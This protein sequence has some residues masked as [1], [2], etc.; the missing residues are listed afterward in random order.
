MSEE[1]LISAVTAAVQAEARAAAHR[2][3]LVAEVTARQC[4]DEDDES[5][6]QLIDGWALAKAQL[7]AACNLGPMAAAK[8]MRIAMALR[9]RLPR[10]AAV[11]ATGSVST[12]VI[13][14]ITWRTRLVTDPDAG[15]LIDAAI[16]AEAADYGTRS[17]KGL[18]DAVDLWVEKFDPDAVVRSDA[19][20]KDIYVEF[21][22]KDDPNGVA[23]FWGRLRVTD[24]KIVQQRLDDLAAT[25]C[26]DDPRPVRQRRADALATLAT[27]GPQATRLTCQ[28]AN[29]ECAGSGKD[30]RATAVVIYALTDRKPPAAT[31]TPPP[32]ARTVPPPNTP[33]PAAPDESEP[34]SPGS[35]ECERDVPEVPGPSGPEAPAARTGPTPGVLLDGGIIPAGML[36]ELVATGATVTALPCMADLGT[37]RRYRPSAALTAFVRTRYLTCAFP[38][39]NRPAH[40]CDLDHVQPWPAG[41]THPGN[42]AP[43]CREHHLVKTHHGW[44]P[45]MSADGT[46]AWTAPTGHTYRKAP[47]IAVLYPDHTVQVPVP[48]HR[49]VTPIAGHHPTAV[50]PTRRRTRAQDQAQRI[51]AERT[52]NCEQ[53]AREEAHNNSDP[54]PF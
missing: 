34:G 19:A 8:Q 35:S 42:L 37:E 45:V 27:L 30:P 2:L 52:H 53:R 24:K 23:S 1:A 41:P 9:T 51:S 14:A 17:E 13:E 47:G 10:T 11:F 7:S 29:P 31:G 20:A 39:C 49:A 50:L 21:D 54:P 25:V 22:D 40:R 33:G 46:I 3:V 12:T 5:A 4:A 18:I 43:T 15:A 48:R 6:H 44:T 36:A 16:A 32:P 26:A 28:C 38:G